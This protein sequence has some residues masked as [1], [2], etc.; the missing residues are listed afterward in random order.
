[1]VFQKTDPDFDIYR[2]N[3]YKLSIQVSLDGFSFSVIQQSD[4][5]LLATYFSPAT[6][7]SANFLGRRVNEWIDNQEILRNN[8]NETKLLYNSDKFTLIP[9]VFYNYEKQN[10]LVSFVF[11]KQAGFETRDN[12][13]EETT[14]N[15]VFS[16]SGSLTEVFQNK[17]PGSAI[18]HPVSEINRKIFEMGKHLEQNIA[19]DFSKSSFNLLL[20]VDG[21]LQVANHYN[22]A[23]PNDVVYYIISVLR[24]TRLNI[25]NTPLL[26][27]GEITKESELY[28]ILQNFFNT[29]EFLTPSLKL[30]SDIFGERSHQFF[31][32]C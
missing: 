23:H 5:K 29:I 27:S 6:V 28:T 8:F 16:I 26:L 31:T 13:M 20:Y 14:A 30:N 17:F 22:F 32:L 9:G 7:S 12:Y 3:E 4:N 10:N 18:Y 11:G 19:V 24:S 15:L 25:K 21:K 1:M 2:T